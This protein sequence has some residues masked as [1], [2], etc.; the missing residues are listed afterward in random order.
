MII[1]DTNVISE[2]WRPA[3]NANVLT[4]LDRQPLSELHLCAPVLAE[5]YFGAERL[6]PGRRRDLLRGVIAE[7]QTGSYRDRILPFDTKAAAQFGKI[8]ALRES[9]GRRIEPLDA[10][11]AAVALSNGMRLATRDIQDFEGIDLELLNPFETT[12]R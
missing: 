3:A 8:G 6:A 10:M 5:L 12:T 4:W 11:I 9:L 7:L 1:L 2:I